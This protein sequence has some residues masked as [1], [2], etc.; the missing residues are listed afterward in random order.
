MGETPFALVYR[1]ECMVP[2]KVEFPGVRRRLLLEREDSNNLMLLDER[3]LVNEGRD[4]ALICIQNYQQA[5]VKYYNTIVRNR[6]FKEGDL[7]L[8][9]VFQSTAE[10]NTGKLRTNWEG[11]YKIIKVV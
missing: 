5:A 8:R 10:R 1:S 4:Q 3:D 6:K 9:K 2:E 7:V 11:P